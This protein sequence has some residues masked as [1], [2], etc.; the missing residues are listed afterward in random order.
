MYNW[1]LQTRSVA[2]CSMS[3]VLVESYVRLATPLAIIVLWDFTKMKVVV[4]GVANNHDKA[5]NVVN[6]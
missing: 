1:K 6:G 3:I 4:L 5:D 2:I